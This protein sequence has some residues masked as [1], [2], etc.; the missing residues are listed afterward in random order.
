M[1]YFTLELCITLLRNY[2]LLYSLM[3]LF[4]IQMLESF[5]AYRL[6]TGALLGYVELSRVFSFFS[7]LPSTF[8]SG[9]EGAVRLPLSSDRTE[10]ERSKPCVVEGTTGLEGTDFLG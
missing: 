3:E 2:V 6:S 4:F 9:G 7:G 10:L 1:Y 8:C 5:L